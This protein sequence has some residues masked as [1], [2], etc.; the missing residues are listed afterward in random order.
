MEIC[1]FPCQHTQ[2]NSN[3]FQQEPKYLPVFKKNFKT[4][5]NSVLVW[6]RLISTV[7][8]QSSPTDQFFLDYHN[9]YFLF[10]WQTCSFEM[11]YIRG[12]ITV[13]S[14]EG[15][16]LSSVTEQWDLN[17]SSG[18]NLKALTTYSSLAKW[19]IMTRC[20]PCVPVSQMGWSLYM[21][22]L[23]KSIRSPLNY[24]LLPQGHGHGLGATCDA[25]FNQIREA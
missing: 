20:V 23:Q 19:T 25:H 9:I 13:Q 12:K 17:W 6:F 7:P 1:I 14:G 2:I 10:T 11:T 22:I 8:Q 4:L 5:K 15:Y 18:H 3:E 16:G 21:L 24:S